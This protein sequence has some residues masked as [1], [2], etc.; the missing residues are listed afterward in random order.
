MIDQ[1]ADSSERAVRIAL[2]EK[3]RVGCKIPIEFYLTRLTSV[4]PHRS[5]LLR[6]SC[7][8]RSPILS[9]YRTTASK[10]S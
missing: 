2:L 4:L 1:S 5:S 9:A 3:E 10:Y 8:V 7:K 6:H